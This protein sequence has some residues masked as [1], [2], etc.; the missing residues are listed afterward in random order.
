M[1]NTLTLRGVLTVATA[2]TA[3]L[4]HLNIIE[5]GTYTP[6]EGYDGFDEVVANVPQPQPVI[7]SKNITANGTY[8]APSGVDGYSPVVVNVPQ[9]QPV[10][11]SKNITANGTYTAPSG[12]DGYSPVVVNVPQPQPVIES[13]NITANGTYTAPSGVDGY[14][15]VVVNVPTGA[16]VTF[17]EQNVKLRDYDDGDTGWQPITTPLVNGK[18]Y[19]VA[20]KDNTWTPSNVYYGILTFSSTTNITIEM[21]DYTATIALQANWIKLDSLSRNI[22]VDLYC[23]V[24][25]VLTEYGDGLGGA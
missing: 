7:E 20:V 22:N 5:N 14:S 10:I 17:N 19:I 2:T 18:T 1:A 21:A 24:A 8:T 11:E 13:K 15:P 4:T 6:P 12:V 3:A 16:T 23:N 25:E 9:P